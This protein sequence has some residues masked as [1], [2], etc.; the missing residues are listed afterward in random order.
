MNRCHYLL[1]EDHSV[2]AVD[3]SATAGLIRWAERWGSLDRRL[4]HDTVA[5]GLTVSTVFLGID[6]QWG[7]GPPLIFETMVF[8]D[9]D[10]EDCFRYAT[11][12]DAMAGHRATVARLKAIARRQKPVKASQAHARAKGED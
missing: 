5:P 2:T 6:H 1:N 7:S 3:V 8:H 12:D 4:A 9:G 11:W 10:G